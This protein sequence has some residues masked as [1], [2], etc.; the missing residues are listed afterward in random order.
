MPIQGML[1][2]A[3][4]NPLKPLKRQELDPNRLEVKAASQLLNQEKAVQA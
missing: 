3:T 2:P 1:P 4:A